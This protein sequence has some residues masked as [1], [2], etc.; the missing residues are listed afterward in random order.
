MLMKWV[1]IQYTPMVPKHVSIRLDASRGMGTETK[2]LNNV[3]LL[4]HDWF[5]SDPEDDLCCM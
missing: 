1:C 5:G 4:D 2:M 3:F